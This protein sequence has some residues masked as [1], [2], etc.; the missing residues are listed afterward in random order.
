MAIP[1]N[2]NIELNKNQI[3]NALWHKL[4]S[5][6]S[7]PVEGQ[8][9]YDTASKRLKYYNGSSWVTIGYGADVLNTARTISFTGDVSGSYSFDGSANKSVDLQVKD[10]SH[11]HTIATIA[12]SSDYNQSN[13]MGPFFTSLVDKS[14]GCRT[15]FTPASAIIIEYST[16]GG[17]TW[18]DY[19]ATDKVKRQLFAM[20]HTTPSIFVGSSEATV[21]AVT[22]DFQTRVT[23]SA[24]DRYTR[25]SK[26]YC[27]FCT[28]RTHCKSRYR[29]FNCSR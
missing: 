3:Q 15:A 8:Y 5:A 14:R 28:Y 13:G 16:D 18:V 11:T 12:D 23:V 21:D 1:F 4:N 10:D 27:S 22:T 17:E 24:T 9:Y 19:G 7:N 20:Q 26:A 29:V 6:P 25:V 2:S